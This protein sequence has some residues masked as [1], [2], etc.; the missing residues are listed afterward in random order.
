MPEPHDSSC[1]ELGERRCPVCG[2]PMVLS[3]VEAAEATPGGGRSFACQES[4]Y[5]ETVAIAFSTRA[6]PRNPNI[7]V[8]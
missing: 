8:R 4:H 1:F 5:A 2:L 3:E 6:G 7:V